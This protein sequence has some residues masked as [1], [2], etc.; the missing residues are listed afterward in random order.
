[1]LVYANRYKKIAFLGRGTSGRVLKVLDQKTGLE[2]AL[3]LLRSTSHTES[4]E[5]MLEGLQTEFQTLK[6]F[7]HPYIAK[8]FDAGFHINEQDL[9]DFDEDFDDFE[10][11]PRQFYIAT[12]LVEGEDLFDATENASPEVIE[13][14]F[15]KSLRA[16]NYIHEKNVLHLDIKPQNIL[17]YKDAN[18]E[19]TIK[20]IDFGFANFYKN[21]ISKYGGKPKTWTIAGTLPFLSPEI[22]SGEVP[23]GRSDL[24]S[25]ACTFYKI[26]TREPVFDAKVEAEYAPRHLQEIP[27]HLSEVKSNLPKYLDAIFEKLLM[28]KPDDR[29]ST[30]TEVIQDLNILSGKSYDI[31]TNETNMSYLPQKGKM[32]GR[33]KELEKFKDY[34]ADR[35]F[36]Q[37]HIKNPYLIVSGNEGFGRS[38][39]LEECKNIAQKDFNT[40]LSWNEFK[41]FD[42][43]DNVPTPVLVVADEVAVEPSDLEYVK[44][45][46]QDKSFLA[47]IAAS[48]SDLESKQDY[49]IELN[50]FTKDQVKEYLLDAT[51]LPDIPKSILEI[52]CQRTQG[53]PLYLSEYL[54]AL[55][56]HQFFRDSNG[57]WS[58]EVLEDLG[59]KLQT[60]GATQFIKLQL[61]K[62]LDDVSLTETQW[63]LLYMMALSGKPTLREISEMTNGGKIESDLNILVGASLLE[64][65][66]EHRYIFANPLLKDVLLEKM[67]PETKEDLCD[68]IAS[69]LQTSD[70]NE[71]KVL[72]YLGRGSNPNACE[73][74]L[75][76]F[77]IQRLHCDYFEAKK[78]LEEVL[79][80]FAS[81]NPKLE[82]KV[83]CLLGELCNEA[84]N[85]KEAQSWLERSLTIEGEATWHAKAFEQQGASFD[86]QGKLD[87]AKQAYQTALELT[88]RDQSLLWLNVA[89]NNRLGRIELDKGDLK[90]AEKIF[91]KALQI[92]KNDLS[93][94]DKPKAILR[95][96]DR[97]YELK[98]EYQT[99]IDILKEFVTVLK[100][101]KNSHFYPKLVYRLAVF[102][103][104]TG[105]LKKSEACLQTC[106]S[107]S[108]KRKTAY[109]LYM[110]YNQL[111]QIAL[112]E[113]RHDE[114]LHHFL[115]AFD[116]VQKSQYPHFVR[117]VISSNVATV[118]LILKNWTEAKKYFE[119][120]VNNIENHSGDEV[121]IYYHI[122]VGLLG[123]ARV[124]RNEKNYDKSDECLEKAKVLYEGKSYIKQM[125]QFYLQEKIYLL[126]E[127]NQV[128]KIEDTLKSLNSLKDQKG[129]REDEYKVFKDDFEELSQ[130]KFSF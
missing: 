24:Y 96:I 98:S 39:F 95:D 44:S 69:Y 51:T 53:N 126:W 57:N 90:K 6:Q 127:K 40:I 12:E 8:V 46:F 119:F 64:T 33:E 105:Q 117:F 2:C 71:E 7:N 11:I 14:L 18:E 118:H 9:E 130:H 81:G 65:D 20:L 59:E 50:P 82:K 36:L 74:L 62:K 16:L 28:K 21:Q 61:N 25:L 38:R 5:A 89:V 31:E 35:L 56:E 111:G 124:Y 120:V 104:K 58:K 15:V 91:T 129:F 47:V 109:W 76:L 79:N 97:L 110:V 80:R 29:Y 94:E 10:D 3:K 123:L 30:A 72:Y 63:N 43:P 66:F 113:G 42:D 102:Y 23:D 49:V 125:E 112:E 32:I 128:D 92:W 106:L 116:L 55:I 107:Q 26:F 115:H 17:V 22:F 41:N 73:H 78:T 87:E 19:L 114:A 103:F 34:Y 60:L 70:E 37:D 83:C 86:Q 54:K 4:N 85:P 48:I 77:E 13:N 108:K 93:D 75:E 67:D 121:Q 88:E 101:H 27:K 84:E 100:T 1:M 68:Q 45:F 52:I 99:A 122:F